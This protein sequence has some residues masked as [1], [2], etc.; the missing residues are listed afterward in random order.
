MRI[1][2]G[3]SSLGTKHRTLSLFLN[4]LGSRHSN[5]NSLRVQAVVRVLAGMDEV[6]AVLRAEC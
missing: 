5:G 6:L 1:G 3:G 2:G 4:V